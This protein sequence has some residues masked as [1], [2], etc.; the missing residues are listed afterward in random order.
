MN[1]DEAFKHYQEGT[2]TDEE[3]AYVKEQF[4]VANSFFQDDSKL[5]AAPVKEAG[6]DEVKKAKKKFKWRYLIVPACVIIGSLIIV[7]TI[8]GGVFGYAASCAKKSISYKRNMCADNAKQA[9]YA[10]VQDRNVQTAI[11]LR[12]PYDFKVDDID[13]EFNYNGRRL[14][15]S[16]YSYFIELEF[17][18]F[19]IEL[20]VDSRT[21]EC[22]VVDFDLD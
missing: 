5:N 6:A 15:D 11:E 4:A 20:E 18:N 10:F 12:S 22:R 8:L 16:Y 9:A 17:S 14:E 19:E 7:A 3:K 2:A 13:A 1:F 21:G